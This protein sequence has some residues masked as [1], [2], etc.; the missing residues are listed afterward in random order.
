MGTECHLLSNHRLQ[1]IVIAVAISFLS[2]IAGVKAAAVIEG[3]VVDA[4]GEPLVGVSVI[5]NL[6]GIGVMTDTDG[7]FE[8]ARARGVTR[9][10]FSSVG[11]QSTQFRAGEIP[12]PVVLKAMYYR[13]EDILVTADRAEGGITPIAFDN[14]SRDEIARDYTVGEFP[15]LLA[16]TPNLYSYSDAGSALGYSYIR[17]RGFD[18]KRIVTYIN[19]VPL[20]DPEDQATYFVDLPDFAANVSDIQVQRGVGNSLYGDASFGGSINIATNSFGRERKTTL[21]TGYGEYFSG[22]ESVSD[23]YKQSVEYSSGLID[24]RWL[25]SGRF[26]RQRTGGYRH[27]SW[28]EGWAYYFSVAR[29]DPRMAT[30]VHIYGGP[31][32]MHLSYWGSSRDV[33]EADRR[34][35]PLTYDNETDNFN[36]PH[37]QIHNTYRFSDK[38]TL[39]NSVYYIR[40][41][42]YYEQYKD[43]RDY[44][45]YNI[46]P[47]LLNIDPS[48]GE[49][50]E[51]GDIVRQQWVQKN[52]TGWNPRLDVSHDRGM[53]SVGGSFYYFKSD[54]WGQVVWAQNVSGELDPRHRYYQYFGTKYVGSVYG[55]EYYNLTE[56]LSA[57]LTAQVRYQKYD[58]DQAA[59][60]AFLGLD[61][62]LDWL[63]F[64]PRLG[65]NYRA[66]E[67]LS[68]FGNLAVSSRTPTDAAIYDAND[69]FILPSLEIESVL[70]DGSDTVG[71]VFG[72]PTAASERVYNLELGWQYR[73]DYY[74]FGMNVFWMD[75]RD[76]I[77]PYGGINENTG[78][79]VTTNADRSVHAGIELTGMYKPLS[80]LTL[81]GNFAYNYNRIK[82]YTATVDI[83][84]V[85][86]ADQTIPLFP[87]YLSNLVADYDFDRLR[88]TYRLRLVGKQYME[89]LN[90]EDLAIDPYTVSSLSASYR[91]INLAGIGDF[92]VQARIDNLF[93][94]KY[95][96]SGYGGDF[97]YD[98]GTA[99]V[100]D[101]WA[102]YY[103]A[104]ERSFYGQ[105]ML[106][107]F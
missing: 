48:T 16:S 65:L 15:L 87:E 54:H 60:G 46:D 40:G 7:R 84:D 53:H 8:L 49:P 45:E 105:V 43:D 1:L 79:L 38:A 97:A 98:D 92:T 61:Y 68:L 26:S 66:S 99:V 70:L 4:D 24:G 36:Q 47:A 30:E 102:E 18:D 52:Q 21:T 74:L 2:A 23:V 6:S 29:L 100:L 76:E 42:G 10:T 80:R 50:Y 51:R 69:P 55:Q 101:G 19:G 75:F 41:K 14:L 27:D 90:I 103:V 56:K 33:I 85:D 83:V 39:S 20:N 22:G 107:L 12:Q 62:N 71:Y 64:S 32:R 67:R 11:Y 35:N 86:F 57:Q 73:T 58:F 77:I 82:D 94:R 63:F 28:Y 93:D 34:A 104:A 31:M 5:T 25:F 9:V 88:L 96:T 13:G 37:Y 17:I 3:T 78:L 95:E 89:L 59:M 72:D 106:E 44:F 81:S 91:M